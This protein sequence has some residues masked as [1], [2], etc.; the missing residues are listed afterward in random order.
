MVDGFGGFLDEEGKAHA[1]RSEEVF[2]AEEE[3]RGREE[4]GGR[5]LLSNLRSLQEKECVCE[6]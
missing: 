1:T 2:L 5:V 4:R 3:E 6:V